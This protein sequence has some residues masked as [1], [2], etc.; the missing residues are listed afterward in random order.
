MEG[1]KGEKEDRQG[2]GGGRT[3]DCSSVML[4]ERLYT[5]NL[6]PAEKS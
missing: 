4:S 6:T 1:E 5:L 3:F 2:G